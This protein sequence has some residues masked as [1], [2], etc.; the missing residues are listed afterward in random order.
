D[1]FDFGQ[2]LCA[3]FF[4]KRHEGILPKPSSLFAGYGDRRKLSRG[5]S[6]SEIA[7]HISVNQARLCLSDL[8]HKHP[9]GESVTKT[10]ND[11]GAVKVQPR[12]RRML[13]RVKTGSCGESFMRQ[14][15]HV[16]PQGFEQW[17]PRRHPFQIVT[18][19]AFAVR[20]TPRITVGQRRKIP[21][22]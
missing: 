3:D 8:A 2:S 5:W 20:R 11:A 22:R 17:M 4:E 6:R 13:Q 1:S 21:I 7:K 14:R 12:R 18:L 15:E 9:L 16:P 10:I 19:G